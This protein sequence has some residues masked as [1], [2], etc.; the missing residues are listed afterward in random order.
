[1]DRPLN[2]LVSSSSSCFFLLHVIFFLF[3]SYICFFGTP[4]WAK[5][6]FTPDGS[7]IFVQESGPG[8]ELATLQYLLARVNE[9]ITTRP[10][11]LDI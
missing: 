7:E 3:M 5:D 9:L 10:P 2:L 6:S 1:M 11:S 4:N 8:V